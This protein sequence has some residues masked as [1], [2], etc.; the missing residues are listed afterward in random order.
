MY[1]PIHIEDALVW[2]S[3]HETELLV[4]LLRIHNDHLVALQ[5][6]LPFPALIFSLYGK[7]SSFVYL[8]LYLLIYIL[9]IY[10]CLY[11][12]VLIFFVLIFFA[13]TYLE[14]QQ[15]CRC[16]REIQPDPILRK[17]MR[18]GRKKRIRGGRVDKKKG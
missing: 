18:K 13:F 15:R 9:F 17:P 16:Q 4:Y 6:Y 11:F 12:F 14:I 5:R 2:M 7:F 10:I 8:F 3:Q 1:L